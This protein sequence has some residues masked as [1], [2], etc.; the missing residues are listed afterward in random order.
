MYREKMK[1][2]SRHY[3][4]LSAEEK[5]QYEELAEA[6][7]QRYFRDLEEFELQNEIIPDQ[8]K[9]RKD[10]PQLHVQK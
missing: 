9:K 7:K 5:A 4:S 2:L 1:Q 6:D 3:E 10:C 8:I